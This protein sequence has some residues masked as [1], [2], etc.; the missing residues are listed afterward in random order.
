MK[1]T[2]SG[3]AVDGQIASTRADDGH[4]GINVKLAAGQQDSA[5]DAGG[6]NRVAIIRD[7]DRSTQ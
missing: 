5:G 7:L 6:V 1:D 3:V 2:E 4:T